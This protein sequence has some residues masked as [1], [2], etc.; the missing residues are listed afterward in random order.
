MLAIQV[1]GHLHAQPAPQGG[2]IV[3]NT[4]TGQWH[5]LNATASALWRDWNA[6]AGFEQSVASLAVNHP[7]VDVERLRADTAVLLGGLMNR[8]LVCA[9]LFASTMTSS[10]AMAEALEDPTAGDGISPPSRLLALLALPVLLLAVLLSRLPFR[11]THATVRG[12]RRYHR[13]QATPQ[14]LSKIVEAVDRAAPYSLGRAACMEKSLAAVLLSAFIGRRAD[15]CI[16]MLPDPYRFHAWVET[17]GNPVKG[18]EEPSA[19]YYLRV[20]TV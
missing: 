17:A 13:R 9:E 5:V 11:I 4:N 2:L 8:G 3:L 15:W 7:D 20:L 19:T 18:K 6:G 12:L 16:G 10:I 1:P 14:T